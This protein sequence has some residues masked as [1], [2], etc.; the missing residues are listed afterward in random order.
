MKELFADSFL[1]VIVFLASILLILQA[2]LGI[3]IWSIVITLYIVIIIAGICFMPVVL[4]V[5]SVD[6][7]ARKILRQT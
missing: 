6:Y 3:L 5:R 2:V 4:V 7:I 1:T